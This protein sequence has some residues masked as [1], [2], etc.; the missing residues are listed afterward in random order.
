MWCPS[1]SPGPELPL[2][3]SKPASVGILLLWPHQGHQSGL[4]FW[5]SHPG[6]PVGS[7]RVLR[8]MHVFWGTRPTVQHPHHS[9]AVTAGVCPCL[10]T[11][12]TTW[13]ISAAHT[14]APLSHPTLLTKHKYKYKVIKNFKTRQWEQSI[15]PSLEPYW[16]RRTVPLAAQVTSHGTS[17]AL[18]LPKGEEWQAGWDGNENLQQVLPGGNNSKGPSFPLHPKT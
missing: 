8:H 5:P 10:H 4:R 6:G 14:R 18:S 13:H 3:P 12:T 2:L 11:L 9:P 16:A 1:A 17:P 7:Q 15:Q